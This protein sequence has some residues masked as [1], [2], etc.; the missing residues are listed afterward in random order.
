MTK[1]LTVRPERLADKLRAVRNFEESVISDA[2]EKQPRIPEMLWFIQ[3]KSMQP[4]GLSRFA[5]ELIQSFPD[6]IGTETLIKV[7]NRALTLK[8]KRTIYEEIPNAGGAGSDADDLLSDGPDILSEI[9]RDCQLQIELK[10][11]DRERFCAHCRAAA[12]L[13]LAE[14]VFKMCDADGAR[15]E[16]TWYFPDLVESILDFMDQHRERTLKRIAM[17]A[18]TDKVFDALDYAKAEQSMVVIEGDSRFGKTESVRAWCE[19]RPG[20]ARLVNVPSSNTVDDLL[21]RVADAF[22]IR[23]T[24]STSKNELKSKVEFVIRHAGIFLVADEGSFLLPQTYHRTTAPARMNWVRTEIVDQGLPFAMVVTPQSFKV[25]IQKF[26]RKTGYVMEQFMG[27]KLTI[28]LPAELDEKDLVA[29]A[30]IHFPEMGN[31]YLG[32]VA[33]QAMLSENYLKAVELISKRARYFA[34][35][36]NRKVTLK[37]LDQAIGE[38][39]PASVQPN[40]DASCDKEISIPARKPGKTPQ[41]LVKAHLTGA[42]RGVKPARNE[43][44][45]PV[46]LPFSSLRGAGPEVAETEL[47]SAEA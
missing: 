39:I 27:R 47:V 12:G 21:R 14:H 3:W 8:D 2:V 36:A 41:I 33:A 9:K 1:A 23:H 38:V 25:E 42:A 13:Y 5:E 29:V 16:G 26:V 34:S 24:Y 19:S 22:G 44:A 40:R 28:T 37:D 43:S 46:T 4:G 45:D 32:Y 11:W 18:V 31:D 7:G 10:Q 20:L 6:R 15:I 35:R 17:T 30:R